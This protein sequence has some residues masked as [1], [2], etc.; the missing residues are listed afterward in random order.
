MPRG[1]N[2]N[3]NASHHK[4]DDFLASKSKQLQNAGIS[5]TR[6]K[7]GISAEMAKRGG[8]VADLAMLSAK[9]Q[10][11]IGNKVIERYKERY[12]KGTYKVEQITVDKLV[13]TTLS[14]VKFSAKPLVNN[15]IGVP[16]KTRKICNSDIDK[17]D[18]TIEIGM[19]YGSSTEELIDTLLHE[20]MK[21]RILTN[22]HGRELYYQFQKSN[23]DDLIHPYIQKVIN[24][25]MKLK[26]IK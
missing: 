15:R 23:D 20:E 10:Q 26:G 18:I 19:Q 11:D 6:M 24:R 8:K 25:Y 4:L 16:G 17:F 14:G 21:A 1:V 3:V 2:V 9:E 7:A 5:K 13:S 22:H 12:A